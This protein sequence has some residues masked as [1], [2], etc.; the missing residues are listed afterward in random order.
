[1][2]KMFAVVLSL[3]IVF[4]LFFGAVGASAAPVSPTNAVDQAENLVNPFSDP[5]QPV[6]AGYGYAHYYAAGGRVDIEVH[7]FYLNPQNARI[8]ATKSEPAL[9]EAVAWF[10]VSLIPAVGNYIGGLGLLGQLQDA[11]FVSDIRR[12]S[13]A[14]QNVK[15]TISTD[16]FYGTST[17]TA[18]YWNGMRDTVKSDSSLN[19]DYLLNDYVTYKY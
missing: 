18:S 15:V 5:D 3:S 2:K 6:S 11:V 12:Y 9:W 17:R 1:M 13:D 7:N 4:G 19:A 14:N 10:G 8:Y 16:N